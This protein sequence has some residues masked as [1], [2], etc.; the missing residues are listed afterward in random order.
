MVSS[1]GEALPGEL[2]QRF[3]GHF[4]AGC[5][6]AKRDDELMTQVQRVWH[7]NM[8]VYVA[9]KVWK[10]MN[11]EGVT[12]ARCTVERLMGQLGRRGVRRGKVGD[13]VAK[14]H[15]ANGAELHNINWAADLSKKGIAQSSAIMVNYLYELDDIE[16]NHEKFL[17]KTVVY[18]KSLN[19]LF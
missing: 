9:G 4:G 12:V 2:G 17:K 18:S 8:L 1:A 11:R 13:S 19:R 14:F 7:A 16:P 15:L 6:R 3:R 10:Q 5:D